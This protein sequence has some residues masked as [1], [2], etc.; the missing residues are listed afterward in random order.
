[1]KSKSHPQTKS[2]FTLIE[3]LVVIAIIAILA[4]LGGGAAVNALDKAKKT[5]ALATAKAVENAVN[6]FYD[7]YANFP[8]SGGSNGSSDTDNIATKDEDIIN[9]LVGIEDSINSKKVRY[10]TIKAAKGPSNGR[11]DGIDYPSDTQADL[12]DPWGEPYRVWLDTNYDEELDDPFPSGT[13][14]RKIRGA[15]ALVAS[16]GS[17]K[18]LNSDRKTDVYSWKN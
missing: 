3:L 15:R 11:R 12:Y 5:T 8:I 17:D 14:N 10:L 1:M 4:A 2:G 18:R 7:E 6:Q 13:G 16:G 9:H